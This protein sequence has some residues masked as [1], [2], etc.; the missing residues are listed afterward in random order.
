MVLAVGAGVVGA[1]VALGSLDVLQNK[2]W[3]LP[4]PPEVVLPSCEGSWRVLQLSVVPVRLAG[5]ADDGHPLLLWWFM[6]PLHPHSSQPHGCPDTL[7][8]GHCSEGPGAAVS[9]RPAGNGVRGLG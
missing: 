7:P 4:L 6:A 5:T 9:V 1:W 3:C 8:A 2:T